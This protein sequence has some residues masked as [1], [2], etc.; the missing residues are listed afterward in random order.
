MKDKLRRFALWLL[1]KTDRVELK[2]LKVDLQT[3]ID[4]SRHV[5]KRN[6]WYHVGSTV[7]WFVKRNDKGEF[8]KFGDVKIFI[9]GEME[10]HYPLEY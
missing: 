6:H 10:A 2:A 9:D 5:P 4:L 8:E 3:C 7:E 1:D